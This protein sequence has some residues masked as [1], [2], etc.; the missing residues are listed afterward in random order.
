MSS[1]I[2]RQHRRHAAPRQE[3]PLNISYGH[4]GT[5]LVMQFT[6][7]TDHVTLTT[8]QADDMIAALQQVKVK[9]AEYQASQLN[10]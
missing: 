9:L 3:G 5:L 4:N 8:R 1:S 10:G 2:A 6:R 7:T